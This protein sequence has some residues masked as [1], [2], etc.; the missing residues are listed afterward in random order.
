MARN[1]DSAAPRYNTFRSVLMT[2]KKNRQTKGTSSESPDVISD[3][4]ANDLIDSAFPTEP[5]TSTEVTYSS[6]LTAIPGEAFDTSPQEFT[7]FLEG[8]F[9]T[10]EELEATLNRFLSPSGS[11]EGVAM[12][13]RVRALV[14]AE[15]L[16]TCDVSGFIDQ[17]FAAFEEI[18]EILNSFHDDASS[19]TRDI[20]SSTTAIVPESAAR[21]SRCSHRTV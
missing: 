6:L 17:V 19:G 9:E 7:D 12:V 21:R 14:P 10:E 4:F 15:L 16:G 1:A 11:D 18:E 13:R 5:H 20:T 8:L 2:A 3:P